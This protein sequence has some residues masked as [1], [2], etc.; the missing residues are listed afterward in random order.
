MQTIRDVVVDPALSQVSIA[1]KNEE[2]IAE[3]L[4]PV[5]SVAKQT[6]KYYVYDKSNFRRNKTARAIGAKANE[7]E[8]GLSTS[9]FSCED[10]ALKE[11][12]PFEILEQADAALNPEVDAAE[13]VTEML[14]VDKEIAL[15]TSMADTAV[16]TQNVTLSGTDQWSDF[17]NSDPFDDIR[18]AINTVQLAIGRRPN[19]LVLGQ[20]TFNKLADHP[21]VVDRIKYTNGTAI[22]A[23]MLAKLFDLEKCIVGKAVYNSANEGQ[24]DSMGYIWGKHAWVA[25]VPKETRLKQVALGFTI[26]YKQREVEKWDD[27]DAKARYVRAHDNYTQEFVAAEAAYLIKNAVA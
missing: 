8:F 16:I 18:T 19:T 21:D 10:H 25:Y 12:V 1:Y 24:T 6:G 11:P 2:Y 7:V 20:T 27:G 14:L 13:S 23:E 26:T 17:D 9:P 15:A 3:Q 22:T 5:V 4:F